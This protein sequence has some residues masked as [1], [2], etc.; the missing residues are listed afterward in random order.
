MHTGGYMVHRPHAP[1]AARAAWA[2]GNGIP[3]ETAAVEG[4]GAAA[5]APQVHARDLPEPR[6]HPLHL[7]SLRNLNREGARAARASKQIPLM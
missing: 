2:A 3:D 4:G 1:S 5:I 7:S 6:S